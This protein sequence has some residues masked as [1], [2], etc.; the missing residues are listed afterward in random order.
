MN[1]AFG[2]TGK[3]TGVK[4]TAEAV[5]KNSSSRFSMKNFNF[6]HVV[7]QWN[8]SAKFGIFF[9]FWLGFFTLAWMKNYCYLPSLRI[10]F[11]WSPVF[12]NF[13]FL[14]W[15]VPFTLNFCIFNLR[16][17]LGT[18]FIFCIRFIQIFITA[19]YLFLECFFISGV[20]FSCLLIVRC[21]H[22]TY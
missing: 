8:M 13:R 1:S 3:A 14:K 15:T 17:S 9:C 2:T 19:V 16:R 6:A 12:G 7:M 5:G 20:K 21:T 11:I 22:L 10:S 4:K 18:L